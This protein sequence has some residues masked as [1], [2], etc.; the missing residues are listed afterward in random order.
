MRPRREEVDAFMNIL[1][2]AENDP[3]GTAIQFAGA[4]NRLTG[5]T[6]RLI[7]TQT[8]YNFDFEKD[9]HIPDLDGR[10]WD[11]VEGL[12]RSSD[13]FH[14]H[15][16]TD[17]SISLGPFQPRQYMQGKKIVHHHHGH[18]DFRANP[19]KY[20]EKY[21]RLGRDKLLVSTPDLLKLLPGARWQ[22]NLV[23]VE[24][25][26]YSPLPCKDPAPVKIVHSPTRKDLKNTDDL[27]RAFGEVKNRFPDVELSVIENEK[28][29][30]CLSLKREGHILF[31]HLQGYHGVSSL[32]GLSQGLTVVAGLDA[33]NQ[34]HIREF[35][36]VP[37]LPWVNTD[38]ARLCRTLGELISDP[39]EM[40]RR[41]KQSR[42]F[43]LDCWNERRV[44]QR[45]VDFW[46]N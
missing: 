22:P 18:P 24:D 34:E 8:R 23:P 31:D 41:G 37:E 10:G 43:M 11:A 30:T 33:W 29:H 25:E 2:I 12:L 40:A 26:L 17:E 16:L 45:L 4:V 15:V 14:F 5:H 21:R 13:I 42:A 28:H 39:E 32:E 3:A 36:G 27:I 35:A 46:A 6:C 44:V 20:R 7:T 19:S 38:S 1:M 9:I